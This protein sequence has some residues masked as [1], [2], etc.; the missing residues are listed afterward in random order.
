SITSDGSRLFIKL[1]NLSDKEKQINLGTGKYSM[2]TVHELSSALDA[3][4]SHTIPK[5]IYPI[6]HELNAFNGSYT[7]K[8]YS[9]TVFDLKKN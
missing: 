3:E 9:V 6:R 1:V 8:A 2:G 4:N 5:N 7:L